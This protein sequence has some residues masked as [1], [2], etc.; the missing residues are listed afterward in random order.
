MSPCIHTNTFYI[1]N[2]SNKSQILYIHNKITKSIT[3]KLY[4]HVYQYGT[5]NSLYILINFLIAQ[6]HQLFFSI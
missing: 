6:V 4:I 2:D 1:Q 3:L 5:T